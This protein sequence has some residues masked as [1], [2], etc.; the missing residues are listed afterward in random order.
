MRS[1]D[2]QTHIYSAYQI[3]R[4]SERYLQT[5]DRPERKLGYQR[6]I[7]RQWELISNYMREYRG[8]VNKSL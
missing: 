1:N 6:E 4:E 2:L 3:I 7:D 8:L 5:S